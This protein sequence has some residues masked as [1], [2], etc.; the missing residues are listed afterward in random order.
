MLCRERSQRGWRVG[1]GSNAA[2]PFSHQLLGW[3]LSQVNGK[4]VPGLMPADKSN[5]INLGAEPLRQLLSPSAVGSSLVGMRSLGRAAEVLQLQ[6]TCPACNG[7]HSMDQLLRLDCRSHST[8]SRVWA[9]SPS[10]AQVTV[11]SFGSI[12]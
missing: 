6:R 12:V 1:H 7:L 3:L 8:A 9:D 10:P 11:T 4:L 5:W 2:F